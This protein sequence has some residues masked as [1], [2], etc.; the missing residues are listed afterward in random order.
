LLENKSSVENY[1]NSLMYIHM[2]QNL[3]SDYIISCGKLGRSS[4]NSDLH[5]SHRRHTWATQTTF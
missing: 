4:H 1:F 2:Q 3:Y 5:N